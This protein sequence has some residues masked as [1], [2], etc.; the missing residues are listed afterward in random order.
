MSP[1][2]KSFGVTHIV[3]KEWWRPVAATIVA[4]SIVSVPNIESPEVD[5]NFSP[6]VLVADI[7][8]DL[9]ASPLEAIK[10]G[11]K[12]MTPTHEITIPSLAFDVIDP[13]T[14][15][16][17]EAEAVEA[18]IINA[19]NQTEEAEQTENAGRANA[20]SSSFT[21]WSVSLQPCGG[22]L[23]P[24]YVAERESHGDYS[25]VNPTGCGGR[26]CGGKWQFDPWTWNNYGGYQFAQDAPPEVQDAKA[27]ELWEGGNGCSHWAAC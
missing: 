26:T 15:T 6:A 3:K 23:P 25:A 21:E 27:R 20:Q 2:S 8:V 11:F 24:C 14:Q 17:I 4:G 9:G 12:L 22:D 18:E 10:S 1:E 19:S 7:R 16:R 5:E 13:I